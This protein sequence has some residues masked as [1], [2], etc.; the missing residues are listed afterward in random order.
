MPDRLNAFSDVG[1]D[2]ALLSLV[3]DEHHSKRVPRLEKLWTY[4][5]NPL[6]PVGS[7]WSSRVQ[8]RPAQYHSLPP[9]LIGSADQATDDRTRNNR[10]VVIENDIGW[11]IETMVDFMFGKPVQIQSAADKPDTRTLIEEVLEKIWE[12]SG[13]IALLQDIAL[14][15]HVYGSVDLLLRINEQALALAAPRQG[16]ADIDRIAAAFRIEIIEPTRGIPILNPDDY[17]TIDAYVIHFD[18]EINQVERESA[19]PRRSIFGRASTWPNSKPHRDRSRR[20]STVTEIFSRGVWHRYEDDELVAHTTSTLLAGTTPVVHI[21]NVA[22]PFRYE[23]RSEVEPLIPLQDELNT[24]L[25]DRANR[26]T[27]QSFRMYLAKGMD[28]STASPSA[29]VRS[30]PPTIPMPACNRSAAMPIRP[31]NPCTSTKSARPWTRSA[32]CPRSPAVSFAPRSATCPAPPHC[33]S[34]SWASSPAPVA[35]VCCMAE[36]SNK[37]AP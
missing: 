25:S 10:E 35:S 22:Q 37:S 27:L 13:G 5:R 33:A 21:Q 9:R 1:L 34:H 3:I 14:L 20:R 7:V 30:G 11:R 16:R 2:K 29:Q 23:G 17:R 28:A 8:W 15:G 4:F 24:R 26:V 32:A 19:S 31:A 12:N 6:E 18:R 36:A